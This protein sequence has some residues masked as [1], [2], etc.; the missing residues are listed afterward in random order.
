MFRKAFD[1]IS[2]LKLTL[3]CLAAAIVLVFAGTIA[4]VH[5]G[6]IEVQERYFQ[7]MFVWWPVG[8]QGLRIPLFPGGHLLGAVLLVNLITAHLRRF[9]WTWRKMGIHLTHAG[10]IIMLAGGLFT[11]LFSVES[12]TRLGA[13][14]TKNYSEDSHRMELAVIDESDKD[15]DQ[16]TAIPDARL[17]R[18]GT[19][20]HSSLPFRIIVRHYYENC[21]L[22]VI[23]R[24][25]AGVPAATQGAGTR[26]TVVPLEKATAP[27]AVNTLGA[28]IE[29]V[30]LPAVGEATAAPL[31]TWLV[32]DE[33]S[34]PQGFTFAG[35]PWRIELRPM[36]YYTDY[37]LTLQR[38]THE[39]YAGT[40]IA[41]NYAS[42]VTLI[43][44]DRSENRDVLIYMN[45]PLRYRGETFYQSGFEKNDTATIL[46]TVHN[47]TFMAPYV[48]CVVVGAG[49]LVQFA[50]QFGGFSRRQ[51]AVSAI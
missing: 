51:K 3:I 38:F 28:V 30:P 17:K 32:S 22:Q 25:Q 6:T 44:P 29:I 10:L 49:L 1:F 21:R 23:D 43:D 42:K 46:Q 35:K 16:V 24:P 7:S 33:L 18:G 36:R 26:I 47:P 39:K 14:E 12:F 9:R 41:K 20:E 2:S 48:A 50:F 11:D 8:S 5:L 37:S 45:H 40:D 19:I 4:Q 13:G 15:L 31:G 34:G 27:D